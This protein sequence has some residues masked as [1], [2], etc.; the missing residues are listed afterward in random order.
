MWDKNTEIPRLEEAR[1][2]KAPRTLWKRLFFF[3]VPSLDVSNQ[4]LNDREFPA[5]ESLVSDIPA[6]DG[7]NY[8][9]FLQ[10]TYNIQGH[11]EN[12]E[13]YEGAKFWEIQRK[14]E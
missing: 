7:E 10:C 11:K 6:G 9:L 4:T 1:R 12:I 5:K 14:K 3:P 2:G 8:I 13:K